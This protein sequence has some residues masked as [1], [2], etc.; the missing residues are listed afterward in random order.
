MEDKGS[1]Y[2][3]LEILTLSDDKEVGKGLWTKV[4]LRLHPPAAGQVAAALCASSNN[5]EPAKGSDHLAAGQYSTPKRQVVKRPVMVL[6]PPST[7]TNAAA[8]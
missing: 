1:S 7:K 3:Q 6:P 2:L 5:S 4:N 8:I